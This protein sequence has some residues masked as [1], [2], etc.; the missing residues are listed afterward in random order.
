M[1]LE[2]VVP[3]QQPLVIAN[4][5]ALKTEL[6]NSLLKYKGLV[7]DCDSQLQEAKTDRANLRK[8][9]EAIDNRRK[10]IKALLMADYT[11]NF[12][13]KVKE[14][15]ALVDEP[16]GLIDE[17]VKNYEAQKKQHK[18]QAIEEIWAEKGAEV[19][20]LVPFEKIF[21]DKWLNAGAS[22]SV[23]ESAIIMRAG[24]IKND[25]AVLENIQSPYKEQAKAFYL[26]SLDL[27]AA[28]A[29]EQNLRES[30]AKIAA[31]NA[32]KQ[33]QVPAP[34]E[35]VSAAKP[36]TEAVSGEALQQ[37]DFR[38]WVTPAQ[39]ALLRG[40]FK[41]NGIKYGSVPGNK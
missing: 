35:H 1:E 5:E 33:A 15:L 30:A 29:E 11:A 27:S 25:L 2:T 37:I 13:P 36:A 19:A 8:L 10:E 14:L 28:M 21:N 18:K 31:Y 34:V 16:I 17:Q 23:I 7:Y 3:Q 12:E 26:K 32:Q 4:F 20:A 40:F 24:Q 9:R 22:L 41:E 38:V 6:K 39:K